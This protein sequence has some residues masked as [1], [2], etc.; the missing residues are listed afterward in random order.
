M[1]FKHCK[2]WA[3]LQSIKGWAV[4][5]KKS[6]KLPQTFHKQIVMEFFY[7][8]D[9]NYLLITKFRMNLRI[10]K[11]ALH[12]CAAVLACASQRGLR[13]QWNKRLLMVSMWHVTR[14]LNFILVFAPDISHRPLE[15]IHEL[16][17]GEFTSIAITT[18]LA[19]SSGKHTLPTS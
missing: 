4:M 14:R 2:R 7:C 17:S 8:S 13:I 12:C 1:F 5:F 15:Y 6:F 9:T 19:D 11:A 3:L 10:P 18:A 16:K